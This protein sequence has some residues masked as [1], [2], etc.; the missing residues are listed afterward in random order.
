M[1][2]RGDVVRSQ[3][4]IAFV[5][6]ATLVT[7]SGCDGKT[8]SRPSVAVQAPPTTVEQVRDALTQRNFSIAADLAQK[9]ATEQPRDAEARLL[10]AQAQAQLE[11]GGSAARALGEAVALGLNDPSAAAANTLFDPVR[12]DPAFRAVVARIDP[13]TAEVRRAPAAGDV[14][15]RDDGSVRAGDVSISADR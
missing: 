4:I 12:G 2:L 7:L 5:A 14:E 1:S 10:E 13:P 8:P 15:I 3:L 11:N 6:M 9:L